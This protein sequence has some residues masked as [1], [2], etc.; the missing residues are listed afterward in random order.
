M[1]LAGGDVHLCI[2]VRPSESRKLGSAPP[3]RRRCS[4]AVALADADEGNPLPRGC[5]H[6]STLDTSG[7]IM[8]FSW[9]NFTTGAPAPVL[10]PAMTARA[11]VCW[12]KS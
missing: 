3:H 11:Q 2:A 12:L 7:R 8:D 5:K 6:A 1:P 9:Y 4:L 10:S